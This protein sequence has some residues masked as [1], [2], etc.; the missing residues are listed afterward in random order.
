MGVNQWTQ[1]VLK[2][3]P[4]SYIFNLLYSE[5]LTGSLNQ[6]PFP[7]I[8]RSIVLRY[9][10]AHAEAH[11]LK[12]IFKHVMPCPLSSKVIQTIAGLD[13]VGLEFNRAHLCRKGSLFSGISTKLK[14]EPHWVE[15]EIQKVFPHYLKPPVL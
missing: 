13:K 12:T 7:Q 4:D 2:G 1:P 15:K 8:A 10:Q 9:A 11:T 5:K 3:V 14:Q 6:L